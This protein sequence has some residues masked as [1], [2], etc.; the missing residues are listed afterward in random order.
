MH[1]TRYKKSLSQPFNVI[2][3]NVVM[4]DVKA[5]RIFGLR[6]GSAPAGYLRGIPRYLTGSLAEM[7]NDRMTHCRRKM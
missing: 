3:C 5:N 7:Q 2:F 6:A 4:Q 1:N